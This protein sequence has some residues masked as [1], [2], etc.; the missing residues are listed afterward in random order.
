MA[1]SPPMSNLTVNKIFCFCFSVCIYSF[2]AGLGFEFKASC[3]QSKMPSV[4]FAVVILEMGVSQTIC[5]G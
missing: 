1:E 3:L 5:L 4:H 2:L